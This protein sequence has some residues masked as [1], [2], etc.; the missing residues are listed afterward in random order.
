MTK[1]IITTV[2]A[3]YIAIN[4]WLNKTAH[5]DDL[6]KFVEE[7]LINSVRYFK[8]HESDHFFYSTSNL[9]VFRSMTDAWN[10]AQDLA[11]KRVI[12]INR[13]DIADLLEPEDADTSTAKEIN[14]DELPDEHLRELCVERFKKATTDIPR[15]DLIAALV[16][17]DARLL[18]ADAEPTGKPH[19][20][21]SGNAEQII[22]SVKSC[23]D[24]AVLNNTLELEKEDKKRKTV[25]AAL[26]ERIEELSK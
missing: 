3:A 2:V 15:E 19:L 14:Y 4:E 5:E 7:Q 17:D 12:K 25:I 10:H 26:N 23:E 8:K 6:K 16:N 18:G 22:E 24:L 13:T 9:Q 1:Q 20:L 21:A 11:D